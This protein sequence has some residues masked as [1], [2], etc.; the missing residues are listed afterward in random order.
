MEEEIVCF[1]LL[2]PALFYFFASNFFSLI[3]E[4]LV[5]KFSKNLVVLIRIDDDVIY[6][7][8]QFYNFFITLGP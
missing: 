8:T 3:E 7:V 6:D 4:K 1:F 2:V 5:S